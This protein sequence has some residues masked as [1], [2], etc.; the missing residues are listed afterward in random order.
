MK[1]PRRKDYKGIR[2]HQHWVKDL[3]E[4]RKWSKVRIGR[5]SYGR[6]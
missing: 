5:L 3:I 6:V 1:Y 4:Y 2:A